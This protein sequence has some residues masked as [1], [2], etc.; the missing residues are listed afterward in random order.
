MRQ[1]SESPATASALYGTMSVPGNTMH[2]VMQA[3]LSAYGGVAWSPQIDTGEGAEVVALVRAAGGAAKRTR[4]RAMRVRRRRGRRAAVVRAAGE[5]VAV[6]R[7]RRARGVV[8]A[9]V[10]QVASSAYCL[11]AASQ[12][13]MTSAQYVSQ[14]TAGLPPVPP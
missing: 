4:V 12:F 7:A 14:V 8:R 11:L 5:R 13:A 2:A 9:D 10:L 6:H 1:A 3:A